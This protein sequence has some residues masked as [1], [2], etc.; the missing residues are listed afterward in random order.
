MQLK[1]FSFDAVDADRRF[2]SQ[3]TTDPRLLLP[4]TRSHPQLFH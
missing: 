3:A 2:S 1:D 4:Y